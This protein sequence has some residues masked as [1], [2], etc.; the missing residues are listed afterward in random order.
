MCA[1]VLWCTGTFRGL[2]FMRELYWL[3]GADEIFIVAGSTS[4]THL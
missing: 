4:G 2:T 1:P 3:S